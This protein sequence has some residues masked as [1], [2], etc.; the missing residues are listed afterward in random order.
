MATKILPNTMRRFEYK[1][2]GSNKFWEI[3]KT[4]DVYGPK[5]GFAVSYGRIGTSGQTR[6]RSFYT[7]WERD[8]AY[9]KI[10]FQKQNKGYFEIKET[11]AQAIVQEKK[12][13][14][15]KAI[16]IKKDPVMKKVSTEIKQKEALDSCFGN[17]RIMDLE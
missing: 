15:Q 11:K 1:G 13:Q 6:P 7:T 14:K 4:K 16:A 8:E 5:Y 10:I 17:R 3:W 2:G 9:L 12:E